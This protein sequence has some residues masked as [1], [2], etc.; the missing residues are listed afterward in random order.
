M[1][2]ITSRVTTTPVSRA[3]ASVPCA[4]A[5]APTPAPRRPKVNSAA[6]RRR[7]VAR[8]DSV[9]LLAQALIGQAERR[10]HVVLVYHERRG[11]PQRALP[12]AEQQEALSKRALD[13]LVRNVRG[14]LAAGAVLH[15]LDPDHEPRPRTSP[16]AAYFSC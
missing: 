8:F 15:E 16:I 6:L 10:V 1:G 11:E 7:T 14:R 13:Q 4:S 5:G 12:G 2:T 3:C 9:G